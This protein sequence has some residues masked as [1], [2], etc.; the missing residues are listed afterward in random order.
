[1][2]EREKPAHTVYHLCVIEPKMRVGF[3]AR[4]GIDT[5]VA[6]PIRPSSLG[7]QTRLGKETALGGAAA[8]RIGERSRIGI[9]ARVG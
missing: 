6:G 8:G 4:I 9:S 1:V 5:V 7:G 3:Q 2:I